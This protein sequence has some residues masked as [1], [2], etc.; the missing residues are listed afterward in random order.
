MSLL[1]NSK[2]LKICLLQMILYFWLFIFDEFW[3]LI[4]IYFALFQEATRREAVT[5]DCHKSPQNSSG[6]T[7]RS[8]GIKFHTYAQQTL[9]LHCDYEILCGKI[10]SLRSFLFET[11][12]LFPRRLALRQLFLRKCIG[13]IIIIQ[14]MFY[15]AEKHSFLIQNLLTLPPSLEML[16][17][18]KLNHNP[19]WSKNCC[20]VVIIK[21]KA[22]RLV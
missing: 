7:R 19:V 2:H 22:A 20:P 12:N 10:G 6:P 3:Y 15:I 17:P 13:C 21:I 1:L 4:K 5:W 8:D 14:E 11:V 18:K 9:S 16:I